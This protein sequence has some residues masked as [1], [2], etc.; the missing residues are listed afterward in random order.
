MGVWRDE[1]K[2]M[3][4]GVEARVEV[5]VW[6]EEEG[7]WGGGFARSREGERR[8]IVPEV[9]LC[10]VV[11]FAFVAPCYDAGCGVWVARREVFAVGSALGW[12]NFLL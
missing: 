2:G 12:V 5:G 3:V 9:P 11:F 4:G 6:M 8:E 7:E 1:W 10:E